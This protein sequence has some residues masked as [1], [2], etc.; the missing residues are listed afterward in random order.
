[1]SDGYETEGA[2]DWVAAVDWATGEQY[3]YSESLDKSTWSPKK[4]RTA[5]GAG[6][7]GDGPVGSG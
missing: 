4:T 5:G 6:G 2:A 1:M 7:G 3:Y